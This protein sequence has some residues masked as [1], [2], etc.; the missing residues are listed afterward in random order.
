MLFKKFE[1]TIFGQDTSL[2][3]EYI[4]RSIFVCRYII[5]HGFMVIIGVLN[6]QFVYHNDQLHFIAVSSLF[7]FLSIYLRVC[8]SF[9][10]YLLFCCSFTGPA[11][12]WKQTRKIL[13]TGGKVA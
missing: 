12:S 13:Y 8:Y 6:F 7:C 1:F 4:H 3:A 10:Y 9:H 11:F 2:L 5:Y